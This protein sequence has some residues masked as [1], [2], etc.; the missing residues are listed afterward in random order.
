MTAGAGRED[1]GRVDERAGGAERAECASDALQLEAL[2]VARAHLYTLFHKLTGGVPDEAVLGALLSEATADVVEELAQG[3][4]V[5]AGFAAFLADMRARC[6]GAGDGSGAAGAVGAADAAASPS[7]PAHLGATAAAELLDAARDEYVRVFV[8]PGALPA[9]PYESPY[10]GAHDAALFQAN[11]LAVRAAYREQGFSLR[12]VQAVPDDHVSALCAF[13]A[14][15]A[16]RSLAAFRA[17]RADDLARQLRAQEAFASAHL[18][19]WLGVY[20]KSVRNSKAGAR[21]VLYPQLL[22]ALAAFAQ[23][24][25]VLL[26]ESAFW[27]ESGALPAEAAGGFEQLAAANDALAALATLR[28]FGIVDNEIVPLN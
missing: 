15:L 21:A 5:L 28:P 18:T 9:S 24:D 19:P 7:A 17:R 8:G 16:G 11:T 22:E 27:A 6:C 23:V 26:E 20:A 2:L 12:R 13:M 4:D 14:Q 3:S 10:T 25:V 1:A